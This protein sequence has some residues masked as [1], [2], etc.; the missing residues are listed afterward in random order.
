[1]KDTNNELY[2]LIKDMEKL[3]DINNF[4]SYICI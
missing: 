2:N 1:M 3:R 4:L